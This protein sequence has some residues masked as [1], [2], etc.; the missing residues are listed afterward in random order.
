MS[1]ETDLQSN[2]VQALGRLPQVAWVMVVTT[3]KYRMK[4]GSFVTT[5]YYHD[6]ADMQSK[7]GMSD[8]IGQLK[9]G[10]FLAIEVKL[11]GETPSDEQYYFIDMVEKN[12]GVSGWVTSVDEALGIVGSMG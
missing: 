12:G 4:G 3:G 10:Q 2:I 7:T 1:R 11:P 9:T 5:G 8:I 6:T